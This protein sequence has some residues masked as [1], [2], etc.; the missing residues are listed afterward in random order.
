M[1]F[2]SPYREPLVVEPYPVGDASPY[3][4]NDYLGLTTVD[5]RLRAGA[6]HG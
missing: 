3:P 2:R 1:W 4:T 6:A 5:L